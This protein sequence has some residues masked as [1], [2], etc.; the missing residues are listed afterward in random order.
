MAPI[1]SDEYKEKKKKEILVSARACFAKKGF[2]A[3]TIDDIVYH[4]GISK[5]AIYNYFSSKDD[6]Y[7][8]LMRNETLEI[9]SELIKTI[10][11]FPTVIEKLNYLFDT[12][13][14]I[15]PFEENNAEEVIV[16]Y[17]FKIYSSRKKD[18]NKILNER[19]HAFFIKLISDILEEGK[20]NGEINRK[21]NSALYA[22]IFWTILDG[23]TIQTLYKDYPYHEAISEMKQMYMNR[24][25][26]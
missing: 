19:K 21:I 12:Y 20:S 24:V 6:I 23:A 3:S 11:Q 14:A 9:S 17:E 15:D 25:R 5:G 1:V 4:S 7:L 26:I 18:V 10:E 16:H 22:D 13:L 2:E 8:E